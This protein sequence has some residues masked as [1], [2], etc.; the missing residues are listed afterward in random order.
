[1]TVLEKIEKEIASLSP[2]DLQKLATWIEEYQAE[3]WDRQIETDVKA[4]KLDNLAAKARADMAAGKVR[5]L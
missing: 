3:L 2:A 4:G 5:P 1:M